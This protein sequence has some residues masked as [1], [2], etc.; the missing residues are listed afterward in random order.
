M[1]WGKA[2]GQGRSPGVWTGI[3]G[4]EVRAKGSDKEAGPVVS[5]GIRCGE[6]GPTAGAGVRPEA[7]QAGAGAGPAAV[8]AGAPQRLK[9][10]QG[11]AKARAKLCRRPPESQEGGLGLLLALTGSSPPPT[12]ALARCPHRKRK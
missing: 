9:A 5:G 12:A 3:P 6:F 11:K 1:L 8:G 10:A 4:L 7:P 2:C